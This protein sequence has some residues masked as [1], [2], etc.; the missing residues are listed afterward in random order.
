MGKNGTIKYVNPSMRIIIINVI[1]QNT[2][3]STQQITFFLQ[4]QDPTVSYL[5][6][7]PFRLK[8]K[9]LESNKRKNV[10]SSKSKSN[11]AIINIREKQS[12][13]KEIQLL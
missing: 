6:G 5:G 7:T 1:G 9:L 12:L 11:K 4:E 8:D 3:Q 13:R 2:N 10:T